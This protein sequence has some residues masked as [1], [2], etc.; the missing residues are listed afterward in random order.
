MSIE[1]FQSLPEYPRQI[2]VL[3]LGCNCKQITRYCL[4]FISDSV[5][6][7]FFAKAGSDSIRFPLL[8]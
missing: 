3:H 6:P 1:P 5:K 2:I 4:D 7:L 8:D